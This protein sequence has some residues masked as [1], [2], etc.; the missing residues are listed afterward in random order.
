MTR[1]LYQSY[2]FGQPLRH[3]FKNHCLSEEVTESLLMSWRQSTKL[4]YGPYIKRW[5]SICASKEFDIL[6][7]PLNFLLEFLLHDFK[8]E[9]GQS[10]STINTTE[11]GVSTIATINDKPAGQN[12]LVKWFMKAVFKTGHLSSASYYLSFENIGSLGINE[13][14]P[15]IQLSK[16]MVIL[17]LWSSRQRGQTLHLPDTRNNYICFWDFLE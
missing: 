11:F 17:M 3:S 7:P 16:K 12:P 6:L 8:E 5:V 1:L 10:Y 14:L 2:Y 9:K 4:Q 13:S 15:M